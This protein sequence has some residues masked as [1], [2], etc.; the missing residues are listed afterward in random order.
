MGE[1]IW[2]ATDSSLSKEIHGTSDPFPL[3]V[4]KQNVN[5]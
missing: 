1:V 5:I 3:K 2:Q 4:T